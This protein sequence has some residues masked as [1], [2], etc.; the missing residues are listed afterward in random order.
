MIDDNDL[1]DEMLAAW[2]YGFLASFEPR[3]NPGIAAPGSAAAFYR[4]ALAMLRRLGNPEEI[5]TVLADN[6]LAVQPARLT[7]TRQA[8]CRGEH[9]AKFARLAVK[10]NSG[11]LGFDYYGE[12]DY[13]APMLD[14]LDRLAES[15]DELTAREVVELTSILDAIAQRH[16]ARK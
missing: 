7:D 11:D 13:R 8:L 3:D 9:H 1:T 10:R 12:D 15:F 14:G 4:A 5:D 16:G 2:L 6:M